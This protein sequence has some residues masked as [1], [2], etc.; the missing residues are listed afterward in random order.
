MKSVLKAILLGSVIAQ[1]QELISGPSV[2]FPTVS[3]GR[4]QQI[5]SIR[6]FMLKYEDEDGNNH[7]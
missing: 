5:G 6:E 7:E 3:D 4:S 1:D 2:D